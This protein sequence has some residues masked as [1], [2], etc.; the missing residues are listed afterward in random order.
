MGAAAVIPLVDQ[1]LVVPVEVGAHHLLRPLD[2]CE[3]LVM[4]TPA[5]DCEVDQPAHSVPCLPRAG[6]CEPWENV[7]FFLGPGRFA[8][9]STAALRELVAVTP[10]LHQSH[11]IRVR[12]R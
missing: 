8:V 6:P 7:R 12:I 5:P 10:R 9:V 3:C 4:V 11:P 1:L 2:E